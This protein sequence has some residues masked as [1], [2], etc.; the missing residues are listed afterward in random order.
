VNEQGGFIL[1]GSLFD[2]EL[3]SRDASIKKENYKG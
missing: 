2:V 1:Q 3:C